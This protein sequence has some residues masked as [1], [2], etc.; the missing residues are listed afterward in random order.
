VVLNLKVR[1]H[2]RQ[3]HAS[4]GLEAAFCGLNIPYCSNA[5][6]KIKFTLEQAMN[7]QRMSK[8]IDLLFL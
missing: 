3:N 2:P 1:G 7:A 5:D 4:E 6:K 8:G